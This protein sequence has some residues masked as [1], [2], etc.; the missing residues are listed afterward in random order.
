MKKNKV[1]K[2]NNGPSKALRDEN[3]KRFCIEYAN[4]GNATRSYMAAFVGT[5]EGTAAVEGSK[6]LRIPKL[7]E[8]IQKIHDE[9]AEKAQ[10][11]GE[12]ILLAAKNLANSDIR[13]IFNLDDHT[14]LPMR[15]WPEDIAKAVAS[16]E[17]KEIF[18]SKGRL[19]GY[20]KKVKL[21]DKPKP[22]ELLGKNRKLWTDVVES[23][24][25]HVV[26]VVKES[27]VKAIL[28][29]LHQEI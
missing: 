7:R 28:E 6:L 1:K 13:R 4:D 18:T 11:S 17:T 25:N 3:R 14:W 8:F 15:E 22:I 10:L 19:I 23:N 2:P 16:V 12:E 20:L 26:Y 21:W 27:D 24:N 29:K 5:N 9:R